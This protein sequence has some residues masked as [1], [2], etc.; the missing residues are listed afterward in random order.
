ML[1]MGC[2]TWAGYLLG[3]I[4]FG[5]LLTRLKLGLDVR[6]SG[7][8]NIGA[9]N[10]A[11]VGGKKLAMWVLFLDALKGALPV[12]LAVWK[13][14][15]Q[16]ALHGAVAGAAVMGHIFP[17]WLRFRGGKGVATSLGVFGVLFPWA[18]LGSVGMYW[19]L[20]LRLRMSSVGS[21]GGLAALVAGAMFTRPPCAYATALWLVAGLIVWAH[22][23]NLV[24]LF[25]GS[26]RKF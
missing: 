24:R 11:R 10:V 7:S 12:G 2:W 6:E 18:T 20:V 26:E 22:R 5:L 9:T 17:V 23:E 16:E 8:G 19:V 1:M 14:P 13:F 21:F 3:S 15:Q 4:P 25:N